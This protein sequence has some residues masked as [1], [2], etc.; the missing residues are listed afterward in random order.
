VIVIAIVI[1]PSKPPPA[2]FCSATVSHISSG[3]G[4]PTQIHTAERKRDRDHHKSE[5]AERRE[6]IDI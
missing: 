2:N 3:G 5:Q 1:D 4:S 6:N